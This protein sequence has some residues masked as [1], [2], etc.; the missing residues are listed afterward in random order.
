[1][2]KM[3]HMTNKK[4]QTAL[5]LAVENG[6]ILYVLSATCTLYNTHA[7][8]HVHVHRCTSESHETGILH[9]QS[10]YAVSSLKGCQK[11][12]DCVPRSTTDCRQCWESSYTF[13][14]CE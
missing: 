3:V 4:G 5:H 14:L 6:H 12:R 7:F 13:G 1:M 2:K 11:D 9:T 8:T 10:Q